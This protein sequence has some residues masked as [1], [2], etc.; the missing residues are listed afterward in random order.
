MTD[1]SSQI[2][3]VDDNAAHRAL[4]RRAIKKSIVEYPILEAEGLADA[5]RLLFSSSDSPVI[6]ALAI[7]DLNLSDGRGT[8]LIAEL[9]SDPKYKTLPIL[10]LSTSTLE[11]DIQE[12]YRQGADCYLAKTDNACTFG[13][14]VSEKVISLL[15]K[16]DHPCH[17]LS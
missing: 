2:V 4:I 10:M 15:K 6:P 13:K 7:I 3:I 5:R 12:C 9:R 11:E 1:S 8:T 16:H 14:E 17:D